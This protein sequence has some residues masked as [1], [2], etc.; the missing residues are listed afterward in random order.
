[1]GKLNRQVDTANLKRL[2]I[3]KINNAGFDVIEH[4]DAEN[5]HITID[6]GLLQINFYPTTETFNF[7]TRERG[8]FKG[9]GLNYALEIA[10]NGKD[11]LLKGKDKFFKGTF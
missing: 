9:T 5:G 2:A 7:F 6:A 1:M 11:K 3:A 10:I 4:P 8:N